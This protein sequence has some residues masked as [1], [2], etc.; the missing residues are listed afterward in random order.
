MIYLLIVFKTNSN[1]AKILSEEN[2]DVID[3]KILE[4]YLIA[5]DPLD[6]SS[7]VDVNIPVGSIYSQF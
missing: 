3:L 1:I 4:E 5:M 2:E 6:G 7:N